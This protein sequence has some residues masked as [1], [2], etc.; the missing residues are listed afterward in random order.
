[1]ESQGGFCSL[2]LGN[3]GLG[4]RDYWFRCT[5]TWIFVVGGLRVEGSG[6]CV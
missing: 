4:F 1:M 2:G 3:I 6:F 5:V